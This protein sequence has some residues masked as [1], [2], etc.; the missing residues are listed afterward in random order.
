MPV[1]D[2]QDVAA[3]RSIDVD[4][5]SHSLL[6]DTNF[7]RLDVDLTK[8]GGDVERTKLRDD[9]KVAVAVVERAVVHRLVAHVNVNRNSMTSPGIA[10]PA[11]RAHSIDEV[12][13][14]G[15]AR[16]LERAPTKLRRV[17]ENFIPVGRKKCCSEIR[18]G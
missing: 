4:G 1:V 2:F 14:P 7:I 11:N 17:G 13:F 6:N 16:Q 5:K 12:R 18:I 15:L 9:Q 10:G 3:R 8:L